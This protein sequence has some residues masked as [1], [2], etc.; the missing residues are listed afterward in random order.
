MQ[1]HDS[2]SDSWGE[3]SWSS[4]I[5][6]NSPLGLF[7]KYIIKS[8]GFYR[9]RSSQYKE[10]VYVGQTG[11]NLRECTRMLG[12]G[13]YSDI[14]NPPWNDPHTAAPILWAYRHENHLDYEL[15]V[16]FADFNTADR[17]CYEDYLL[18]LHRIEHGQSTLANHGRLHPF[19][20]RPTNKR[21]GIQTK[22]LDNA[23]NYESIKPAIYNNKD[24]LN[25]KWL[26]LEWSQFKPI[27]D[28][29]SDIPSSS[30]VYRIK[31]G[32]DI[33]YFGESKNLKNR[34]ISHSKNINFEK[35][36][37]S[38]HEMFGAYPYQLK[39]REVDLIGAYYL[40]TK[41]SPKYQY[42]PK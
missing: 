26:G 33:V 32:E 3:L 42:N 17:Q 28:I 6:L 22:R 13:V 31:I 2:N 14:D 36:L 8:P 1:L 39:E 4:W 38:V 20:T 19:W 34:I 11:R 15:S 5:P 23:K 40:S 25:D 35:S 16:A 12:R 10:L 18:Y 24:Y 7:Q 37:V 30:G 9:I 21:K 29:I 27:G 41:S